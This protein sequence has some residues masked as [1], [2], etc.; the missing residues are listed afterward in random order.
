LG[1]GVARSLFSAVD[2]LAAGPAR[3]HWLGKVRMLGI[4]VV[5][6]W[7][8]PI[9]LLTVQAALANIDPSMERRRPIWGRNPL[10]I[11]HRIT[12]PLM[13]PEFPRWSTL[14]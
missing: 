9:M 12:L 4:V 10:T 1:F 13:R 14:Y 5:E 8:Y 7:L 11:F 2:L 3:E 6:A